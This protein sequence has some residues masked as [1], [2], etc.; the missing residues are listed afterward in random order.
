MKKALFVSTVALLAATS[1]AVAVPYGATVITP[2]GTG[3]TTY[4]QAMTADGK[5][6]VGTSGGNQGYIYNTTNGN[7]YTIDRTTGGRTCTIAAGVGYRTSGG[8]DQ[9]VVYG[10]QS[11]GHQAFFQH[12][13]STEP[14]TSGSLWGAGTVSLHPIGVNAGLGVGSTNVLASQGIGTDLIY[15][16]APKQA[17]T[18]IQEFSMYVGSTITNNEDATAGKLTGGGVSYTGISGYQKPVTVN[19]AWIRKYGSAGVF[20]AAP[21]PAAIFGMAA[22]GSRAVGYNPTTGLG[23]FVADLDPTTG[24]F[25]TV[26]S[27]P[28]LA[29]TTAQSVC[30]GMSANGMLAV[31]TNYGATATGAYFTG[32]GNRAVMYDLSDLGNIQEIDLTSWAAGRGV[33]RSFTQLNKAYSIGVDGDGNYLVTGYGTITG[34]AVR[35]FVLK[36][37][38][39]ASLAFLTLGALPLLRRRR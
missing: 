28:T 4:G 32:T 15:V 20:Q 36:I 12:N 35:G 38:E 18:N 29:G 1:L 37:P 16:T 9:L 6:I 23:T 39:P 26:T 11:E 33:L 27:L 7:M 19:Q 34:G 5:Y 3:T 13:L 2:F 8:V 30:Y 22:N 24:N 14:T 31:G 10:A 17:S 21:S 25:T